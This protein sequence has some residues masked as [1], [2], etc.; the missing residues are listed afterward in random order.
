MSKTARSWQTYFNSR[1][2]EGANEKNP[3]TSIT[4]DAF[5][6]PPPRGGELL[7]ALSLACHDLISIPA[8]ARGRTSKPTTEHNRIAYFNSR[9]R[10]GA[11][12]R[13][14]RLA[15]RTRIFQFP[16]PRGGEQARSSGAS[17]SVIISIPAPARGRTTCGKRSSSKTTYFNSRPREGA[18]LI[19]RRSNSAAFY[20]NSR[21]REGANGK[22][23]V[24]LRYIPPISIPAPARGRTPARRRGNR[25]RHFNSRPREGANDFVGFQPVVVADFNSRPREGANLLHVSIQIRLSLISIP[26]PARGRTPAVF[27]THTADYFNSRPREGAN[28]SIPYGN[29]KENHFNSRPR[30]GANSRL[31]DIMP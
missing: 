27:C 23:P 7:F 20:F 31:L 15:T 4:A 29:K 25:S 13:R 21:P 16:P 28:R 17:Q 1:P 24:T 18:N 19:P 10:E 11:N 8:P 30:E 3:N 5:Q 2:R 6:F 14:P 9:P 22:A 26:A 12:P